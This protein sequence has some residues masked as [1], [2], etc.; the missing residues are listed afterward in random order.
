VAEA[1]NDGQKQSFS[2]AQSLRVAEQRRKIPRV[3]NS[4]PED[5]AANTSI[6]NDSI[7]RVE[8]NFMFSK[9]KLKYRVKNLPIDRWSI[10]EAAE[11]LENLHMKLNNTIIAW[12]AE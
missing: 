2:L 10:E 3:S 6:A 8:A 1:L 7:V 9:G 5:T 12:L 4:L 11:R